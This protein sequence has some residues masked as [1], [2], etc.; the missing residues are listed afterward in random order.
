MNNY[1]NRGLHKQDPD[2]DDRYGSAQEWAND[3]DEALIE[4]ADS[5]R[6]EAL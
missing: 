4:K 6:E 5:K 2:Y 1:P 3:L